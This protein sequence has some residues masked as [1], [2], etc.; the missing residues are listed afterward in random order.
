M[1]GRSVLYRLIARLPVD[2][3]TNTAP[4]PDPPAGAAGRVN[5]FR[6]PDAHSALSPQNNG[7]AAP[8]PIVDSSNS[9]YQ[10]DCTNATYLYFYD[11]YHRIY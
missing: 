2:T 7:L 10:V 1:Q 6:A 3:S 8:S 11:R 5:G 9:S 4:V